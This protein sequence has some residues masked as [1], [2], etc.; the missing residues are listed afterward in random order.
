MMQDSIRVAVVSCSSYQ[1][2][3]FNVYGQIADRNDLDLVIHLGD[4]IYE[5]PAGGYGFNPSVGRIDS[6]VPELLTLS[7]YRIR[8]SWYKLDAD[9]R[10]MHQHY[11]L[12][13]IYDDHE[14]AND[15]WK[16]GAQ[17][18]NPGEGSFPARQFKA[19]KA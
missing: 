19:Y 6:P 16:D 14:L 13:A 4:Y 8:H 1:A 7:D 18:H 10:R 5:Y 15:S 17:N 11:P 3:F 12:I 9:S 2:G